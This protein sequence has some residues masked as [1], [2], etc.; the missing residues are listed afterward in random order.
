MNSP[1]YFAGP[2]IANRIGAAFVPVRKAGK[3][4]GETTRVAYVKEYGTVRLIIMHIRHE[5]FAN[6][7]GR[8]R[9]I[10]KCRLVQSK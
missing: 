6:V 7:C 9:I 1:S 8:G 3:L 10:L 2:W 5:T 4:P